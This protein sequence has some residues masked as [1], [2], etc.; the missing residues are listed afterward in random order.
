MQHDG[1]T[2]VYPVEIVEQIIGYL[3]SMQIPPQ[4]HIWQE[5]YNWYRLEDVPGWVPGNLLALIALRGV[6][7]DFAY[8]CSLETVYGLVPFA[9]NTRNLVYCSNKLSYP[10]LREG[11]AIREMHKM[12]S[13]QRRQWNT[14]S[15]VIMNNAAYL[16]ANPTLILN[17]R[18]LSDLIREWKYQRRNMMLGREGAGCF[19][20]LHKKKYRASDHVE[21]VVYGNG[22]HEWWRGRQL[23]GDA[24][25]AVNPFGR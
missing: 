25:P 20:T 16:K 11:I 19:P 1:T 18:V 7:R 21:P 13:P 10:L 23:H 17:P 12:I 9:T 2:C 14:C 24:G 22:P 15:V 5:G 3:R 8:A 6:S 4:I